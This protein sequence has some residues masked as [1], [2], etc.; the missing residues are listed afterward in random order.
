ML[1]FLSVQLGMRP[2]PTLP[3]LLFFTYAFLGYI[4]ECIVLT[5]EKKQL[6]INRGFVRH[7]PFCIIYGFGAMAGYMV[8]QPFADN[9]MLLFLF[10][11]VGATCFEY[12]VAM[13]QIRIFGDF[14]WDYT[15][16]RFN[17]KGILCLESTLG[18]GLLGILIVKVFH[19]ALAGAVAAIPQQVGMFLAVALPG[20]Y[21]LDFF[22]SARTAYL[23]KR[24]REECG[25][26]MQ[27][28]E[29]NV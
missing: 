13:L 28:D 14:W 23:H 26:T 8:L 9:F 7:L 29:I 12:A 18:W 22:V 11:A 16:K 17:Y 3:V 24:E 6:V 15:E 5:A 2:D 21:V 1:Q 10:G 25:E 19:G 27:Q 20:A 4:M